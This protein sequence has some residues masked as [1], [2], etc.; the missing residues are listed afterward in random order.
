MHVLA[1]RRCELFLDDRTADRGEVVTLRRPVLEGR[2]VDLDVL[3][4]FSI[5]APAT[6]HHW[7][8]MAGP[9]ARRVEQRA[10]ARFQCEL[11]LED[12]TANVELA[13][14]RTTQ[15]WQRR[16]ERCRNDQKLRGGQIGRASCRERV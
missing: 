16:A 8:L 3:T 5:V 12:H 11:G 10:E 1:E 7:L 15:P 13:A 6:A 9:A 14:L 4:A 2:S